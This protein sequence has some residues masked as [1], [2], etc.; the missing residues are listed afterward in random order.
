MITLKYIKS[1]IA[2]EL[3]FASGL[4]KTDEG[5]KL[6]RKA[7]NLIRFL[8]IIQKY[9]ELEPTEEFCKSEYERLTKKLRITIDSY[10]RY[11]PIFQEKKKQ[12]FDSE[13]KIALTRLQIKTLKFILQ[14]EEDNL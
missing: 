2:K 14:L 1:E 13:H 9:L 5:K 4:E 6:K 7:A 3:K 10:N 12:E 11:I 8:R